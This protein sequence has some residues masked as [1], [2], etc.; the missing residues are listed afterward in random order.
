MKKKFVAFTLAEV[1]I[2]LGIIGIVAALTIPTVV[3]YF[4][5]K[6][7]EA[8]FKKADNI[9]Q[10]ALQKTV[11][12]Y[13][14]TSITD[15]NIRGGRVTNQNFAELQHEVEGL[16]EIWLKQFNS[17]KP[18]NGNVLYANG[19]SI[20]S[21][22]GVRSA[23]YYGDYFGYGTPYQLTDGMLISKMSAYNGGPNHPAE[24]RFIFD[25]NGP[26]K[27]PNRYG[28]DVFVYNSLVK[29]ECNPVQGS[30]ER[31]KGC[32]QWA[33]ANKN[34]IKPNK[35]YWDILFKPAS[36]WQNN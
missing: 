11:T 18:V 25:T 10:Q 24:I 8:R 36:Y 30:S 13:G 28:H 20:Y 5:A 2:T 6:E 7:L 12:E 31:D 17:I 3:N 14:Y 26:Y 15:F 33:H 35:P 16:N 21:I 4:K 23:G 34:P 22:L 19:I 32:Y 29:R 1:L 27:G 9:I